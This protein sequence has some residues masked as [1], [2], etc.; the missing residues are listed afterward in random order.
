[1]PK[2]TARITPVV[3]SQV[4]TVVTTPAMPRIPPQD[5]HRAS[6]TSLHRRG[7]AFRDITCPVRN[8][9]PTGPDKA[10]DHTG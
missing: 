5:P 7:R 2:G 10:D 9:R 8:D 1:M 3:R 6:R 4:S